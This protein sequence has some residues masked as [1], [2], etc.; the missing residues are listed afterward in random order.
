MVYRG[1]ASAPLPITPPDS[2]RDLPSAMVRRIP[3]L[4]VVLT[5]T[6]FG[7]L[8][9]VSCSGGNEAVK[10]AEK[11]FARGDFDAAETSLGKTKGEREDA[12]RLR[13]T[14]ARAVRKAGLI[15]IETI[16]ARAGEADRRTLFD[17]LRRL[18][19]RNSDPLLKQESKVAISR[20]EDLYASGVSRNQ[21][22]RKRPDWYL[23]TGEAITAPPGEDPTA[24]YAAV[25]A[26]PIDDRLARHEER[27]EVPRVTPRET[28]REVPREAPR[29]T[30]R[31]E[32]STPV[33][34][35]TPETPTLFASDSPEEF[36]T[37]APLESLAELETMLAVEEFGRARLRAGDL[38]GAKA[39]WE[40]AARRA[41]FDV[42]RADYLAMARE[43]DDRL[44]LRRELIDG[45][46]S[47]PSS[48]QEHGY[49]A[50]AAAGVHLD[51][52]FVTWHQLPLEEW[53]AA[54]ELVSLSA[55]AELGLIHERMAQHDVQ[56]SWRRLS[57]L[58]QEGRV[59]EDE[60]FA[61]VARHRREP[62]PRKGYVFVGGDWLDAAVAE[63]EA[64][65]GEGRR[66]VAAFARAK[67][68]EREDLF[69][70]LYEEGFVDEL[71]AS[72]QERWEELAKRFDKDPAGKRLRRLAE[73]RE[74]LDR[75]R[76][77][78][79]VLIFDEE[80]YFYPYNPPACPPDKAARYAGVQRRVD[81]L[82]GAVREVWKDATRVS[83][84]GPIAKIVEEA[85]WLVE[86]E[87]RIEIASILPDA[88]PYWALFL[89]LERGEVDLASFAWDEHEASR[90]AFSRA[91]RAYN[92]RLWART[93]TV[94]QG[95]LAT[96][97]ARKQVEVTNDYRLMLGREALA[98]N[99]LIQAAA[100]DHS[101]YMAATGDFGHFEPDPERKG[102][103]ER[104]ARRGY[105]RGKGENC[106]AGGGDPMGA[107]VGWCHSSGHHR[108]LLGVGHRE[109][110]SGLV[111]RYWTQDFGADESFQAELS[112]WSD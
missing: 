36:T 109:M 60:V 44:R 25:P 80:E 3:L 68:Q 56:R 37:D 40:E 57:H 89:D 4:H 48:F 6:L 43:V 45:F 2:S 58:A 29:E 82:V 1:E 23:D 91:V 101:D 71:R 18:P 103:R 98:W 105:D 83:L 38:L 88:W 78:A 104:M 106:H 111:G 74:E 72:L 52:S 77:A 54:G 35:A 8:S 94:E 24:E 64:R 55:R 53:L 27:R 65:Q 34:V 22:A 87:D 73:R 32:P 79:L 10:E 51:G 66:L 47:L 70:E 17:E 26:P 59:E 5:W 28:S 62:V 112:G 76:E 33:V 85:R 84:D 21:S 20:L 75:R 13:I 63:T 19:G 14:E 61:L 69:W 95:M 16:V 49:R 31:E 110:A 96:V 108:N 107:H 50:V 67:G 15:K 93:E 90:L 99:P 46:A 41:E 39:A 81:V 42:E 7:A 11:A 97:A 92:Q 9:L 102:P 86:H 30:P 12:L 100:H